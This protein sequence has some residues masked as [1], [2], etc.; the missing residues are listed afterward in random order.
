NEAREVADA[1]A[2]FER[3]DPE[4]KQLASL[5]ADNGAAEDLAV[6]PG[7]DLDKAVSLALGL[8]PVNVGIGP[9]QDADAA[10]FVAR[11]RLGQTDLREVRVGVGD[12]GYRSGTG[13]GPQAEQRVSDHDARMIVGEMGE[14]CVA[15]HVADGIDARICGLEL[16]VHLDA[17]SVVDD[18]GTLE[19]QALD[20]RLPPGSDQQMAAFDDI[21]L[22]LLADMHAAPLHGAFHALDSRALVQHDALLDKAIDQHAGCLGVFMGEKGSGIDD[23]DVGAEHAMSLGDLHADRATAQHNQMLDALAHIEDRLVGKVGH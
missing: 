15:D 2:A 17:A 7:D 19:A 3:Y 12:A 14:L 8:R 20:V 13:A 22:A 18:A 1:Q 5:G 6:R 21:G 10:I 11:L 4:L 9:A 16:L 23:G